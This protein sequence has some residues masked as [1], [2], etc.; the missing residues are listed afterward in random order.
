MREP[1]T[2]RAD[3]AACGRFTL[4]VVHHAGGSLRRR[5]V[6]GLSS[7]SVVCACATTK[8]ASGRQVRPAR[9]LRVAT[10]P[11]L[12]ASTSAYARVRVDLD[13]RHLL[14]HRATTFDYARE[15]AH[16]NSTSPVNFLR[17][18]AVEHG[19]CASE[20][21]RAETVLAPLV[22]LTITAGS[23][24]TRGPP[25]LAQTSVFE[26]AVRKLILQSVIR[27][28]VGIRKR[29]TYVFHTTLTSDTR[30]RFSLPLRGLIVRPY[31]LPTPSQLA[32]M[33]TVVVPV[34]GRPV[35]PARAQADVCRGT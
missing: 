21:G 17:P 9:E 12:S 22:L 20:V 33:P 35:R 2:M 23:A 18:C 4:A 19:H 15:A 14:N 26:D 5:S 8:R 1:G 34:V 32:A 13:R 16:I 3:G 30:Q 25:H 29:K 6:R 7:S 27:T 31:H 10:R 28:S 11:T 24:T